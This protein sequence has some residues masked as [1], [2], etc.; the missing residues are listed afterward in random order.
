LGRRRPRS[1]RGARQEADSMRTD[2]LEQELER[3]RL[4]YFPAQRRYIEEQRPRD[5]AT[6]LLRNTQLG[7]PELLR[8]PRPR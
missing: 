2:S 5:R 3:Y 7:E 4:R 1:R 6:F 8:Q